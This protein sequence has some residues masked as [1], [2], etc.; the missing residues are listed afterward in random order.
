M[1][2]RNRS[3]LDMAR[4]R[5]VQEAERRHRRLNTDLSKRI[6][7][8]DIIERDNLW[9]M[10]Q[11]LGNL[12]G[13][14]LPIEGSAG[15]LINANHP[16]NLQ[17]YTASHEYGHFVLGH[18]VSLDEAES[19]QPHRSEHNLQEAAAQSFAAYFL[20]PMQLVNTVLRS[21]GLPLKPESLKPIEAYHFSLEVGVS[22][23]AAVNHLATLNK[24]PW[25][26]ANE[27]RGQEPKFIKAE[28]GR[29]TRP[30]DVHA[31]VWELD[32]S[33]S[34]RI[35][36]IRVNDELHIRLPETPSTGYIWTVDKAIIAD[37]RRDSSEGESANGAFLALVDE[38]FEPG[39]HPGEL[40]LGAG[41]LRRFVFRSLKP[42]KHTL[43]L[44]NR[45][46]WQANTRGLKTFEISLDISSNDIQGLRER[47]QESLLAVGA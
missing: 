30:Q 10:F 35:F 26:V 33:D 25:R 22:Y 44:V 21:M 38:K 17:R 1:I 11:P 46:P 2:G 16:L 3:S 41:G 14:Y 6:D 45:R 31:D 15:I 42:G 12:Y 27:L 37:L 28:I 9:L 7:I 39:A 47:Q 8:F 13:S 5:A 19:I 34:G 32:E 18:E 24:I 23:A 40:R 43:Q 20:M 36:H 4:A 29:G